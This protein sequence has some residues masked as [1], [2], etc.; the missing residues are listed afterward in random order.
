MSVLSSA[1]L[2]IMDIAMRI[3]VDSRQSAP[4]PPS[5]TRSP[6]R[7]RSR[8]RGKKLWNQSKKAM[9]TG[10]RNKSKHWLPYSGNT[11]ATSLWFLPKWTR[12]ETKSKEN[13]RSCRR[14][15]PPWPMLFLKE[16]FPP[17]LWK[18]SQLKWKSRRTI[19]SHREP[20]KTTNL[21]F[22]YLNKTNSFIQNQK[23]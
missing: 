21:W 19:S 10:L 3:P 13:S 14:R 18:R 6:F 8:K 16:K 4:S 23:R 20:E 9:P 22:S 5:S 1:W 15:T 2:L 7:T 12:P 11:A 17:K